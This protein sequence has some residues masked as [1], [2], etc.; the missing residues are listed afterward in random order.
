MQDNHTHENI[1]IAST[2]EKT[3]VTKFL[4]C[5]N[6]QRFLHIE[7]HIRMKQYPV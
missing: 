3:G 2:Y 6:N 7:C 5:Q 4:Y 1:N